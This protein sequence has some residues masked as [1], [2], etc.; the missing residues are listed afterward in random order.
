MNPD[1]PLKFCSIAFAVLWTAGMVVWNGALQ[2]HEMIVLAV[3]GALGGFGWY[4]AMR[5]TFKFLRTATTIAR[6][7][8]L[9]WPSPRQNVPPPPRPRTDG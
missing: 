6:D 1:T 3:C 9:I 5:R 8:I 4:W 7:N 2:L